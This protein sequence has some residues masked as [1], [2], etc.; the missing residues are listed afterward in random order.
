MINM[1]DSTQV[2]V[3]LPKELLEGIDEVV[4][5]EGYTSRQELIRTL[6]REKIREDARKRLA[7]VVRE[8]APRLKGV[9]EN[10]LWRTFEEARK[11]VWKKRAEH[12]SR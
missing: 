12:R 10:E 7:E 8:I 3:K 5:E 11:E 2:L 6:I 1:E 4:K 9:P